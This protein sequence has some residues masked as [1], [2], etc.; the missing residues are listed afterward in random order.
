MIE[1][2][3]RFFRINEGIAL[4]L[5]KG[6]DILEN[7]ELQAVITAALS[8]AAVYFGALMLPLA[9]L[10]VMMIIDYITGLTAAWIGKRLSSRCGIAGILKKTGYMALIAVAAAADY[11]IAGSFSGDISQKEMPLWFGL[12]VTV[13]LLI[14]EMISILENLSEIGVPVPEFLMK[15]VIRLKNNPDLNDNQKK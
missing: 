5:K 3:T 10:I 9:V 14:N 11:L 1:N 15:I 4:Y 13:W 8:A 2:H 6:G 7:K 12:L